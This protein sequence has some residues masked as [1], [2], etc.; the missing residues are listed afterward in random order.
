MMK[1]AVIVMLSLVCCIGLLGCGNNVYERRGDTSNTLYVGAVAASFP[2]SFMPWL[3]RD[4]VAPTISSMIYSTLFSYD[5][6]ADRFTPLIASEWYYVDQ[7]GDPIVHPDGSTD[8]ERLEELYAGDEST[9]FPVKV[10]LNEDATWSDGTPLTVEDVYYTF[11]IA[12]NNALSNH[13]GALA[14]TSDLQHG[15]DGGVLTE[16]GM[17]TYDRGAAEMGYAISEAEKDTVIILHVNKV[18]GAVTTLFSTILILPE[19]IWEPIVSTENQ[20]NSKNPTAATLY[21]YQHPIGCGP[22]LLDVGV[23]NAQVIVLRRNENYHMTDEDASP[24]FK[25]ETIKLVLY[26]ELNVAIYALLKGHIDILDAA[27]S[28]NYLSLFTARENLYVSNAPGLFTQTLVMNV[29][30]VAAE[31]TPLRA[32]F[33]DKDFRKAIAL[34]IDQTEL[35]R[36]ILNG[37]GATMSAGLMSAALDDLYNPDADALP[38]TMTERLAMANA[39]LDG[40]YPEK[41]EEGYRLLNGVRLSYSVLGSTAEQETVG[42]LQI[43][44]QKIGIELKYTAKGSSPEKTFLYTS[45]F[46]MTLHGVTFSLSNIDIMYL[47]HFVTQGTSSNYGRLSDP[48]LTAKIQEMRAT[49]NLNRKYELIRELQVAIAE[50]YYK[51]PLYASNVLSVARTDRYT[52]YVTVTGTTVFNTETL[53]NLVLTEQVNP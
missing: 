53:Q 10:I 43:Q 48:A 38:V 5:D 39:I 51:I 31:R 47:A 30:P 29:N 11:D 2:V 36:T 26:Q 8:Y 6:E 13:A 19:H 42:F 21:A 16:Q 49:L 40:L 9:Y 15:Y 45:K 28:S 46:D 1:K 20:L 35:I 24:L 22:Y 27:I 41:D 37:S 44:L 12:T 14:W 25:V 50:E 23:S 34:A 3:S 32:L 17:F 18:L 7:N 4:G 33:A 52:G